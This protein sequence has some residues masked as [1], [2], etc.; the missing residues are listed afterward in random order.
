M[1]Y[2]QNSLI[3]MEL[4]VTVTVFVVKLSSVCSVIWVV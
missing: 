2:P 1:I 3:E 4:D